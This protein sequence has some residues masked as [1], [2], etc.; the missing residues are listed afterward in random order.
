MDISNKEL[1]AACYACPYISPPSGNIPNLNEKGPVSLEPIS[2]ENHIFWTP[3][4]ATQNCIALST[5]NQMITASRTAFMTPS[6]QAVS[7]LERQ[8]IEILKSHI[9]FKENNGKFFNYKCPITREEFIIEIK[10]KYK[11]EGLDATVYIC[12]VP[13]SQGNPEFNPGEYRLEQAIMKM[14]TP[15][16]D[17]IIFLQGNSA[18]Y[19]PLIWFGRQVVTLADNTKCYKTLT[20]LV[21]ITDLSLRILGTVGFCFLLA[22]SHL[23][24][25]K[26]NSQLMTFCTTKLH[27]WSGLN[28]T[29]YIVFNPSDEAKKKVAANA[30]GRSLFGSFG[31]SIFLYKNLSTKEKVFCAIAQSSL[32]YLFIFKPFQARF[33]AKALF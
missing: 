16:F 22:K 3:T 30:L 33:Q 32:I 20:A 11:P 19:N 12:R 26:K 4:A 29:K 7:S 15:W 6:Q 1:Q 23:W 27:N 24:F 28:W 17:G 21:T 9:R 8:K 14:L 13:N 10:E 25:N 2:L 5:A 18:K 31:S